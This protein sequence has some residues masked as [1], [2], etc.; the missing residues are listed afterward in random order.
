[1]FQ[2]LHVRLLV[3]DFPACF[4]FYRDT[5]GLTPRFNLDDIYAEFDVAGQTV[6]LY[7]QPLMTDALGTAEKPAS[8]D[9][10]DAAMLVLTTD[11]V[12][13]AAAALQSRGAAPVAPPQNRPNWEMRTVHFRDPEGHLIEING[14]LT[15]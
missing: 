5:L 11:D 15:Q 13:A 2:S 7:R 4:R 6:A 3:T 1:M 12:D 14:P 8:A 10:Q 9:M